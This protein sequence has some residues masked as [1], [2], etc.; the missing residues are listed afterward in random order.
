MA[1]FGNEAQSVDWLT[2]K[3]AGKKK[4]DTDQKLREAKLARKRAAEEEELK[5]ASTNRKMV[6]EFSQLLVA[7]LQEVVQCSHPC[8][9]P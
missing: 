6:A 2:R 4:F 9:Y 3:A 5:E 7:S 1:E 8:S